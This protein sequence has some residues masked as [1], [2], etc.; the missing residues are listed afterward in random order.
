MLLSNE[1]RVIN[2]FKEML[3]LWKTNAL[4]IMKYKITNTDKIIS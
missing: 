1:E 4:G 3:T 2:G